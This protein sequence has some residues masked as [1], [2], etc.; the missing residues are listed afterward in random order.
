MLTFNFDYFLGL[1]PRLATAIPYTAEVIVGSI[2]LC[3]IVGMIIAVIRIA[4][5]PVLH[6]FCE[7]WL[8]YNRSMPFI[9]D[10]YLVYF[11][12]PVIVRVMGRAG[13]CDD[14]VSRPG[15]YRDRADPSGSLA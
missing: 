12:L 11:V 13:S 7:I 9:L 14:P 10:L 1:F 8:S 15:N 5:I 6:Q 2:L 4:R 3:L